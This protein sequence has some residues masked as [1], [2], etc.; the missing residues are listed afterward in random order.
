MT[1]MGPI[2]FGKNDLEPS[3]PLLALLTPSLYLTFPL[4]LSLTHTYRDTRTNKMLLRTRTRTRTH[5]F[6]A[7]SV[8]IFV[9]SISVPN[10]LTFSL[11]DLQFLICSLSHQTS[12]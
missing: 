3:L 7:Q 4:T 12:V 2:C 11:V 8:C 10:F 9:I 5:V 1:K 6:F